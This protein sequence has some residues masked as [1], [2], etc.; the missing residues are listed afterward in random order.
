MALKSEL[1]ENPY[2]PP[3]EENA[4]AAQEFDR[5]EQFDSEEDY[6]EAVAIWPRCPQCGRRR[7]TRCP[8]CKTSSDL[9]PLGDSTFWDPRSEEERAIAAASD[10]ATGHS[11]GC[12]GNCG[13]GGHDN[14]HEHDNSGC[15]CHNRHDDALYDESDNAATLDGEIMPGLPSSRR[16]K[17]AHEKTSE[18]F[19]DLSDERERARSWDAANVPV[20]LCHICSEAFTPQFPRT[21]EWCGYDFGDGVDP[22][23]F[24][25]NEDENG[26]SDFLKRAED[27]PNEDDEANP[28][29][30]LWTIIGLGAL[31][32]VM[33]YYMST[34]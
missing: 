19:D 7:I 29:R 26:V 33:M 22:S 1:E 28:S 31:F 11:C 18:V 5:R 23:E 32:L 16:V 24:A 9:F 30:V 10:A 21:C 13:C 34:L 8:I 3:I 17:C 2:E 14:A 6:L 15:R 12:G 4:V 25:D 27:G 20:A